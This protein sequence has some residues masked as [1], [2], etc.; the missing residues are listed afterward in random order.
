LDRRFERPGGGKRTSGVPRR[1]TSTG[2]LGK[3][4]E[5]DGPTLDFKKMVAAR[6]EQEP[7]SHAVAEGESEHGQFGGNLRYD[8]KQPQRQPQ[9]AVR[10]LAKSGLRRV[11]Y[12]VTG[13]PPAKF[14]LG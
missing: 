4:V 9:G 8:L 3:R 6:A 5:H 11:V 10:Y 13:K 2:R 12:D 14:A 1:F 7:A